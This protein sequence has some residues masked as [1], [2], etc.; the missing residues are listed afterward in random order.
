MTNLVACD[1]DGTLLD[2][3]NRIM[4]GTKDVIQA[5]HHAGGSFMIATGRLDHDIVY[6]ENQL[7]IAGEFRIS[8]NGAVIKDK[9]NRILLKKEIHSDVAQKLMRDL[10]EWDV[11]IE[12]SD[13]NHRYFPSPRKEGEVAEFIDSS[14]IEP[15]LEQKVG[16]QIQPIIFLIFGNVG[17]FA[18]IKQ[19]LSKKYDGYVDFIATSPHTLEILPHDVSKGTA[20]E[21]TM[22]KLKANSKQVI[23]IGDSEND[24]SLFDVAGYSFAMEHASEAVKQKATV[25][26]TSVKACM[27]EILE[28]LKAK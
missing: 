4:A 17:I 22:E 7:G 19:R 15:D 21:K 9:E 6:V 24:L 26:R 14:I 20:L 16:V 5:F 10:K 11:R 13:I 23:A 8:Q 27:E 12:V 28:Q 18:E 25:V 1:L 3:Q 2:K